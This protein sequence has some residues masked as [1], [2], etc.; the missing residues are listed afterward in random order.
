MNSTREIT[1]SEVLRLDD[2]QSLDPRVVG[3]KA[4]RQALLMR[5]GFTVPGGFVLTLAASRFFYRANDL[6]YDSLPAA[7]T[8]AAIPRTICTLLE[9]LPDGPWAVR[10]SAT[11]EDVL[12]ASFAGLYR[13]VLNVNGA[14]QLRSAIRK[15]WAAVA[16]PGPRA[17]GAPLNNGD[18]QLALLIQRQLQARVS[19]VAC[20]IDPVSGESRTIV[21]AARRPSA[22]VQ[23][24]TQGEQWSVGR[25]RKA[26]CRDDHGILS[27]NDALEVADLAERIAEHFG[28]PQEIEWAFE[29]Q[30]LYVLQ[31]R[32]IAALNW[33][34]QAPAPGAFVRNVRLGEWLG[35]PLS[36]LAADWLVPALERDASDFRR[37]WVGLPLPE[38]ASVLVNGWFYASVNQGP[39]RI[40]DALRMISR[41]FLHLTL[42]PRRGTI[43]FLGRL[44]DPAA[45]YALREWDEIVMPRQA[46]LILDGE[47][48]LSELDAPRL[49][50]F[51]DELVSAAAQGFSLISAICG[52]AWKAE[53]LLAEY[54]QRH[55]KGL[56]DEP[57]QFLLCGLDNDLTSSNAVF[58]L[59]WAEP[60]ASELGFKVDDNALN[61]Q[62]ERARELRKRALEDV[63]KT[64]SGRRRARRQFNHLFKRAAERASQR[65]QCI[66]KVTG[67]WTLMR[68]ALLKFGAQCVEAGLLDVATDV[69][70]LK[71]AELVAFANDQPPDMRLTVRERRRTYHRQQAANPPLVLGE[72]PTSFKRALKIA[73]VLR[74]PARSTHDDMIV[75]LPASPGRGRGRVRTA[76]TPPE[77][78]ALRPGEVL[79]VPLLTPAWVPLAAHAAAA[80]VDTGNHLMHASLLAR[81]IGLPC[82]VGTGDATL[83][84]RNGELVEV[85]GSAGT[86]A[87]IHS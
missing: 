68:K 3:F 10:S 14:E 83:R 19:G 20:T 17:Y 74:W 62:R 45:R 6:N 42:H 35:A 50:E 72:L 48:Q 38:P 79:V 77:L 87:Q 4:S 18:P 52:A 7:F 76:R 63:L 47:D 2:P 28:G 34:W 86:V 21:A 25:D 37:R 60:T 61:A 81:E 5:D 15:C 73:E 32:P 11:N 22:I 24:T 54:Y 26:V 57:P 58:S 64:L 39:Q 29:D 43:I 67:V 9:D 75:G 8:R 80:V 78:A 13:T 36:P 31:S 53:L 1:D 49:L 69:F 55:V 56:L 23:G 59:D 40:G 70:F 51:I 30:R 65:S 16:L 46:E 66:S 27:E 84:L 44:S 41:M 71:R 12:D 33:E 85:D 82:V